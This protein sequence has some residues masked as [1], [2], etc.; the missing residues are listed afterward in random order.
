MTYRHHI[1]T[2]AAVV[3]YLAMTLTMGCHSGGQPTQVPPLG[4]GSPIR[5]VEKASQPAPDAIAVVPDRPAIQGSALIGATPLEGATVSLYTITG[6]AMMPSAVTDATGRFAIPVDPAIAPGTVLRAVAK[7]GDT[8]LYG[9]V[10]IPLTKAAAMAIKALDADAAELRLD[11]GTTIAVKQLFPKLL[12][13]MA[14]DSQTADSRNRVMAFVND[15][16]Q[17]GAEIGRDLAGSQSDDR[18]ARALQ[19]TQA[20]PTNQSIDA[21]AKAAA[22]FGRQQTP[23]VQQIE[24]MNSAIVANIREG[25]AL[26][27]PQNSV[28]GDRLI[29]A[30]QI[31]RSGP[32]T[33]EVVNQGQRELV[34]VAE[35]VPTAANQV[36]P[37]ITGLSVP[38][39]RGG[40]GGGGGGGGEKRI[41]AP[42]LTGLTPDGGPTS[43]GTMVTLQ[44]TGFTGATAV[45]FGAIPATSFTVDGDQEIT[46]RA[47]LGTGTQLVTVTTAGGTSE[48][49][50]YT[51]RA[52]PAITE[53]SQS[54][55]PAAGGE[56]TTIHGRGFTGATA[57]NFGETEATSFTVVSDTEITATSPV[58][59]GE[60]QVTVTTAVGT[61]QGATYTYAAA[62][63]LTRIYPMTSGS[64]MGGY[65]VI[66][67]GA[68]LDE[69]TAV[70]FG[71]T[72]ATIEYN[73]GN[74][75]YLRVPAHAAGTVSVTVTSP[76]GVS[77]GIEWTYNDG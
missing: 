10:Q 5:S 7:R 12:E 1:T 19:E 74:R 20:A 70:M 53:L 71:D 56:L 39:F 72:P 13:V 68:D 6:Q 48:G 75:I 34:T 55:G 63:S 66:I 40:G 42:A 41:S 31:V 3:A 26:L 27:T 64:T 24:R 49:V 51:Y 2:K 36:I 67:L 54:S 60:K 30:P 8:E 57:V 33:V 43:G 47:P 22:A 35:G 52:A 14:S 77:N 58:G 62:L 9:L 69:A 16:R 21:L 44:G 17:A 23:L 50:A 18:V 76:A 46:A 59:T 37:L 4:P 28:V 29:P 65:R 73:M 38:T 45:F 61:S 11:L 25:G 32:T 15:I